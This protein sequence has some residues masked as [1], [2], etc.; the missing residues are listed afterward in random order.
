MKR[1]K[2]YKNIKLWK[3]FRLY[4]LGN[5]SYSQIICY[6]RVLLSAF[7]GNCLRSLQFLSNYVH[8]IW[9]KLNRFR[10]TNTLFHFTIC[11]TKCIP[12][13]S[14][15]NRVLLLAFSGNCLPSLQCLSNYVYSIWRKLD[16]FHVTNTLFH[17]SIC[18]TKC[19]PT[20]PPR[21]FKV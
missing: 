16:T 5:F 7:S 15:R 10:V 6:Y 4:L 9:R 2:H 19:I 18:C 21:N 11:C 8:S 17:F 3:I 1:T 12:T 20:Y 13:Y 14:P